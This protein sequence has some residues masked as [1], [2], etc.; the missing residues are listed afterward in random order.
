MSYA[1]VLR[2]PCDKTPQLIITIVIPHIL[3]D[4]VAITAPEISTK[5]TDCS[6]D[7]RRL[8]FVS[9]RFWYWSLRQA[10]VSSPLHC[11]C[12]PAQLN[13]EWVITG[14]DQP[15]YRVW[16][17]PLSQGDSVCRGHNAGVRVTGPRCRTLWQTSRVQGLWCGSSWGSDRHFILYFCSHGENKR[18]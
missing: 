18:F 16:H 11:A 2:W 9:T 8:R 10:C 5:T 7:S 15:P 13:S 3:C 6:S 14:W 4:S 12:F 1:S 17:S